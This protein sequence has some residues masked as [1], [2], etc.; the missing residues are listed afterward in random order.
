MTDKALIREQ[1]TGRRV[2]ITILCMV[3][4]TWR[5]RL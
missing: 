2:I 4:I 1:G 3:M 5:L